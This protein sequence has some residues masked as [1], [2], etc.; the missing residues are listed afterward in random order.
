MTRYVAWVAGL[1]VVVVGLAIVA[2]TAGSPVPGGVSATG[3]PAA[4][5]P[6]AA[7]SGP[8]TLPAISPADLPSEARATLALIAAGG[9]FP[10]D[11]DG[12]VYQNRE[13]LL[14]IRPAG[15]YHEYTVETPG[16]ADRG[17]RR[18]VVAASG[19]SYW[20]ADHYASF[21]RIVP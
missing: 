21:A 17:S 18:I 15:T 3:R 7:G 13:R 19:E 2:A 20:T 4:T 14:P 10:Y 16:S 12:S 8:V 1:A 9:P 11:A 5:G 6:V